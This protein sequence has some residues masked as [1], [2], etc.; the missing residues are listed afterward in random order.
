M[1]LMAAP[2]AILMMSLIS[3]G[4]VPGL[5]VLWWLAIVF[6]FLFEIRKG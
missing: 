2:V 6:S 3:E 5:A 4:F 1:I